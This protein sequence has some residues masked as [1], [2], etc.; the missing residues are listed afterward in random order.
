MPQAVKGELHRLLFF[1]TVVHGMKS[2]S[3]GTG[4]TEA[5]ARLLFALHQESRQL[6]QGFGPLPKTV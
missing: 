1:T 3:E 5:S 4:S 6:F 2:H